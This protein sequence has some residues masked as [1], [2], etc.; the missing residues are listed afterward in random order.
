MNEYLDKI[1]KKM[2]GEPLTSRS[3]FNEK[4]HLR[5]ERKRERQARKK[6]RNRS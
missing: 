3:T 6:Q 1:L 4:K 2:I 5:A